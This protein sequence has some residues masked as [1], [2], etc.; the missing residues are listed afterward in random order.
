VYVYANGD[1]LLNKLD[2]IVHLIDYI[3][4]NCSVNDNGTTLMFQDLCGT[5]SCLTENNAVKVL[6]VQ[7]NCLHFKCYKIVCVRLESTPKT[8]T[9]LLNYVWPTLASTLQVSMLTLDQI[10]TV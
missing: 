5:W 10:F 4:N 8:G 1:N 2:E 3:Y 7:I 6:K 9:N